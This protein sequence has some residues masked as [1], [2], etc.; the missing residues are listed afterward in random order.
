MRRHAE[1]RDFF[2]FQFNVRIDS[3]VG[4]DVASIQ[5]LTVGIQSFE[6]LFQRATDRRDFFF[7]F[8]RQVVE[9]FVLRR[10][11]IDLVTDTVEASHHQCGKREVGVTA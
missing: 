9:V 11:R 3:V 1:T 4:E 5:E 7:L 10:A 8:R 2:H 6:R